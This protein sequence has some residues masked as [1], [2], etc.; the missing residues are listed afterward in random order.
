MSDGKTEAHGSSMTAHQV[1]SGL[2]AT[3]SDYTEYETLFEAFDQYLDED[4]SPETSDETWQHFFKQHFLRA[5]EFFEKTHTDLET[6]SRYVARQPVPAAVLNPSHSLMATN[7]LFDDLFPDAETANLIEELKSTKQ[8]S[9]VPKLVSGQ[10]DTPIL[11][12]TGRD[13]EEIEVL[14]IS[15]V[16]LLDETLERRTTCLALRLAKP[17]WKPQLE[18]LLVGVYDLT[19]SEIEI[20]KSIF[21]VADLNLVAKRRERSI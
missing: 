8:W 12:Q 10:L 11:I 7:A 15:P 21:E 4:F 9:L 5:N 13:D 14:I 3:L 19:R 17:I 6:A 16:E 18:E 20:I 2:Y 1:L